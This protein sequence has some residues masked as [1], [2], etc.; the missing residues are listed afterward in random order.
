MLFYTVVLALASLS[1]WALG[2]AGWPYGLAATA[3]SGW[4]VFTAIRV[5]RDRQNADGRSLTKDA[6]ARQCFRFSLIYLFALF[7]ALAVDHWV[8]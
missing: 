4:F 2:Y 1:P 5:V 7:T 8:R 3:L 6:P